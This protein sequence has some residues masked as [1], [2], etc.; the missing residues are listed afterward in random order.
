MRPG[1]FWPHG[2]VSRELVPQNGYWNV[3]A[4]LMTGVCPQLEQKVGIGI[5]SSTRIRTKMGHFA[6]AKSNTFVMR[7]PSASSS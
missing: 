4:P 7:T 6:P 2:I 5:W 3:I 1:I